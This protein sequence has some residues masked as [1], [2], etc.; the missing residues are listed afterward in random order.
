MEAFSIIEFM[1][2]LVQECKKEKAHT[3]WLIQRMS[4]ACPLDSI[5]EAC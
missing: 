4:A 3:P 2:L 1:R 5:M